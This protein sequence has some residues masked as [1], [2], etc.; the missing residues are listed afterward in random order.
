MTKNLVFLDETGMWLNFTRMYG[1]SKRGQ[2]CHAKRSKQKGEIV[3]LIGAMSMA[4]VIA[5]LTYEGGTTQESFLFFIQTI[6][7]PVLW[8]GAVVVMDN[9][10]VHTNQAVK[11]AIEAVGATV[12]FLPT[13]SPELNAIEMLWSKLKAWLRK[14]QPRTKED[15]DNALT[16]FIN[17]LE[18]KDIIGYFIEV[19]ARTAL[20]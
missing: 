12:L 11:E 9:L 14:I 5:S 10:N 16:T 8:K 19:D 6:L 7:V 17:S 13:Y 20:I 15:L 2:R 1:R 18:Q 4:G 3:T